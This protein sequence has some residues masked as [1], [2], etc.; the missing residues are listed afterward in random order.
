MTVSRVIVRLATPADAPNAIALVRASISELCVDDHQHDLAT[1]ERWL[2]NKTVESFLRWLA[3]P[4]SYLVV[5]ELGD[6]LQGVGSARKGG[7][8]TL[9]YVAPG[10]QGA[11][12]GSAILSELEAR[13]ARWGD[14]ELSLTSSRRA[15]AFYER[16]GFVAA[17][18]PQRKFG[19][20]IEYPYRKALDP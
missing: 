15:R 5:A 1:L 7:L 3:D 12:V 18:E 2:S 19:V 8:V 17:G 14:R 6:A 16:R 9:L 11:G 13:A 10:R 20:L 4:D